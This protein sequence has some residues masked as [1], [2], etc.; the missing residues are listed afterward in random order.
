MR[1]SRFSVFVA[2]ALA[3]TSFAIVAGCGGKSSSP[4][5]TGGGGGG[6]GGTTLNSGNLAMS[7]GSFT[8][9]FN[10]AGVFGYHCGIHPIQMS[11]YSV[12]VSSSSAVDSV[13][14]T[15]LGVNAGLDK[16]AVTIKTGGKVRWVNADAS[17]I[18]SI[19]S[20]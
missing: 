17:A 2:A 3:T 11:G 5:N 12:T 16:P 14:V 7:G 20:D 13:L 15:V 6:G 8:F 4:T 9:T 19:V 18:H 1:I 10:T